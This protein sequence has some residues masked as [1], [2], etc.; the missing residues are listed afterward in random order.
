M[1]R[2]PLCEIKVQDTLSSTNSNLNNK[3]AS[4]SSQSLLN[5]FKT[6]QNENELPTGP[7]KIYENIPFN[8]TKETTTTNPSAST[9]DLTSNIITP[10]RPLHH[11]SE[12]EVNSR[13]KTSSLSK[14]K[15]KSKFNAFIRRQKT[16]L[17]AVD[18][19]VTRNCPEINFESKLKFNFLYTITPQKLLSH[20]FARNQKNLKMQEET[21]AKTVKV[22]QKLSFGHSTPAENIHEGFR[23]SSS[24]N[25]LKERGV[26]CLNS[27]K[28][29]SGSLKVKGMTINFGQ[30]V[31]MPS[32][33]MKVFKFVI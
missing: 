32:G 24:T 11:G 1:R 3:L 23:N 2:A 6:L 22:E 27:L 20:V 14:L 13:R 30:S 19:R 15:H 33:K 16:M 26:V 8:S 21:P 4:D 18:S 12:D 28:M 9:R 7:K 31:E 17:R 10:P 5:R 25:I 29:N